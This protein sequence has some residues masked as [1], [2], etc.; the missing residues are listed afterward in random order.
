LIGYL[1][2][3]FGLSSG[4][5]TVRTCIEPGLSLPLDNCISRGII[6][7]ELVSNAMKYAFD[8][9]SEGEIVI[10][11]HGVLTYITSA[12][13]VPFRH[14]LRCSVTGLPLSTAQ[15]PILDLLPGEKEP[16]IGIPVGFSGSGWAK[17]G[18]EKCLDLMPFSGFW[19]GGI[20]PSF[21]QSERNLDLFSTGTEK[22][23]L[24]GFSGFDRCTNWGKG[25][26]KWLICPH[27]PDP[28]FQG[29]PTKDR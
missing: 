15:N 27:S 5:L 4:N 14:A 18:G 11:F 24:S 29:S 20:S 22:K 7:N 2:T 23:R 10:E 28:L 1:K 25:A 12:I 6:I 9:G 26:R 3:S 19:E 17:I 13:F 8:K 16:H 21:Y